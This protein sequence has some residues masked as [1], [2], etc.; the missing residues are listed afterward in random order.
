MENE[1]PPKIEEPK[2][3]IKKSSNGIIIASSIISAALLIFSGVELY[4]AKTSSISSL[5]QKSVAVA[6]QTAALQEEVTPSNGV[7]LPVMW[8]NLGEQMVQ[9]GVINEAAFTAL[10]ANQ[11]GLP[12]DMQAMLDSSSTGQ[13]TMTPANSGIILNLFW[14]LGLGN[15]NP[16]LENG[17]MQDAQYGGA[18]N[19]ASTGGW[20]LADGKAM[21]HYDAHQFVTLTSA[22]QSL[23]EDV[24]KN[25]YRPCCGN[26]VY[27]PDC[28]HGMAMLGLLELMASQGATEDQMYKTAFAVNS[29]WFP[30]DYLT[31]AQYLQSKG[32]DWST[33]NPKDILSATYSS[34]AGYQQI[35]A[36]MAT[37]AATNTG[38][39]SDSPGGCGV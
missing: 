31:I 11:G 20:T 10:Y 22:E 25:I 5:P 1:E 13:I 39:A 34:G 8:G 30:S 19:F 16:I 15:K 2:A 23:V 9:A 7:V 17:P 27:F 14:A 21:A 4:I 29:Y 36:A 24:A 32:I 28:N 38:G 12:P 18:G 37:P 26:S 33:V 3:E 35:V 6:N